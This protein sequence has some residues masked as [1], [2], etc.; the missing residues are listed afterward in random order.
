M[1][2][3]LARPRVGAE[4][5]LSFVAVVGVLFVVLA[6]LCHPVRGI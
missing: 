2:D 5:Q 4:G 1:M 6:L 3:A